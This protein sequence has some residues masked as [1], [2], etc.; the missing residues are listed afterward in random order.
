[1]TFTY[2]LLEDEL[3][4]AVI[5]KK[6]VKERSFYKKMIGKTWRSR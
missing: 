5:E 2:R 1:M 6:M 3:P 4:L